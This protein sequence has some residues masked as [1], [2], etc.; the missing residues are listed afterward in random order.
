MP[1]FKRGENAVSSMVCP[2]WCCFMKPFQEQNTLAYTGKLLLAKFLAIWMISNTWWKLEPGKLSAEK[3]SP[4]LSITEKTLCLFSYHQ[5]TR[6]GEHG[7]VIYH[8]CIV[9]CS[10]HRNIV[11]SSACVCNSKNEINYFSIS[12]ANCKSGQWLDPDNFWEVSS[13]EYLLGMLCGAPVSLGR[14]NIC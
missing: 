7:E 12:A 4:V 1:V 14:E 10:L 5:D 13:H 3:W 8:S 6:R 2:K 11:Y 9:T